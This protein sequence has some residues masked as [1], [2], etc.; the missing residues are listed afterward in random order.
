MK[1][2]NLLFI[3]FSLFL[4]SFAIFGSLHRIAR[5]QEEIPEGLNITGVMM[6][7][8]E[9]ACLLVILRGPLRKIKGIYI[10]AILWLLIIPVTLTFAEFALKANLAYVVFWPLAFLAS[11]YFVSRNVAF[12]TKMRKLFIVVFCITGL[13]FLH[14][15]FTSS[16]DSLYQ[17]NVIFF[18]LLAL[19]WI[20]LIKNN[21]IRN[22]L[23]SVLF[24]LVLLSLKRSSLLI[25]V[26]ALIPYIFS[27]LNKRNKILGIVTMA[28]LLLLLGG[29]FYKI[30]QKL[31][32]T[33]IERFNSIEEDSGSGRLLIYKRVIDLQKSSSSYEWLFGHGHYGVKKDSIS[34]LSA[35]NDFLEI[36]YDYGIII[37]ILHIFLCINVTKRLIRLRKEKSPLYYSY[38]S[39]FAIFLVMSMVSHLILYATYFIFLAIYW[40]AIEGIKYKQKIRI[41]TDENTVSISRIPF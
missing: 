40:G 15:R 28:F 13:L 27:Y 23:I 22:I 20:M 35:H 18:P 6:V 10:I 1:K 36:L 12:F 5:M 39:G 21:I 30:N 41:S 19:P 32:N 37:F 8:L 24:L 34:Q 3:L 14:A 7:L 29:S 17:I 38:F 26:I 16:V 4:L 2:D 11:F 33:I 9:L 31:D 25:I